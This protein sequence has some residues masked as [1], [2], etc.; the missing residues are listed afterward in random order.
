MSVLG[1]A[2][3]ATGTT[4]Y[5]TSHGIVPERATVYN[6]MRVN[7]G[8]VARSV[9]TP[10]LGLDVSY[11]RLNS[12]IRVTTDASW[13]TPITSFHTPLTSAS[14]FP[15]MTVFGA[16]GTHSVNI[17][18]I[19]GSVTMWDGSRMDNVIIAIGP[20]LN[21]GDSGAALVRG[22]RVYGTLFGGASGIVGFSPAPMYG[23][24][25]VGL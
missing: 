22:T 2:R 8:T 3:N 18:N 7:I 13:N 14:G 5:G 9:L 24:I 19:S 16:N 20:S 11:I 25:H 15:V 1:H 23:S 21:P 4:A 10:F 17:T 12:N 6:G